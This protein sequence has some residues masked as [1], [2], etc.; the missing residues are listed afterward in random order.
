MEGRMNQVARIA[1]KAGKLMLWGARRAL[2]PA[3]LL[4]VGAPVAAYQ[5]LTASGVAMTEAL[6]VA[7]VF[8]LVAVLLDATRARRLNLFGALALGAVAFGLAG[9]VVFRDPRFLLVKDSA[10]TG[11]LGLACLGSLLASRPMMF[12]LGRQLIG[13]GNPEKLAA[14]DAQWQSASFRSGVRR[15]TLVWGAAL[16]GEASL[17]VALSFVLAPAAL[18]AISPLLALGTFGPLALWTLRRRAARDRQL[19]IQTSA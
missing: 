7:A 4:N 15:V 9:T 5:I 11:V 10:V 13:G 17:R 14:Y 1:T 18:L 8:P 6:I 16:V 12:V 3:N 19:A 2:H